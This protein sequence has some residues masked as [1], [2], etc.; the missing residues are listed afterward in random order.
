MEKSS[1]TTPLETPTG[2]S[3]LRLSSSLAARRRNFVR[4]VDQRILP[5]SLIPNRSL[6]FQNT[7]V[8]LVERNLLD[9]EYVQ[10]GTNG[11][12]AAAAYEKC[13]WIKMFANCDHSGNLLQVFDVYPR[14]PGRYKNNLITDLQLGLLLSLAP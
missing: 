10:E 8:G 7:A 6:L 2:R 11:G 12:V 13:G 3:V 1:W 9:V 14:P 5:P 4:H